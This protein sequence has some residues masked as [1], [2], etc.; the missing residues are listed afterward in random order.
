M[1]YLARLESGIQGLDTLLQGGLV[2]GASYIVQGRPGSGKT[3]FANQ[4]AFHHARNGGRVLF[5]TLLSES[6]ER[7]FQFLSTLSFFD[8]QRV[9]DEIQFVSAF[10]TLESEGLEEVVKL[11]RRE[12]TRQKATV[13]VVDGVLNARSRAEHTIDTKKFIAELQGHAAFAGCTTLFLTSARLDDSSPEHTMVDG[14]IEL[15]EELLANRAIRRLHLRK[16]R[17]SGAVPGLHE[18]QITSQGVV[19][20]PRLEAVLGGRGSADD[21]VEE[22]VPS[23]VPDLDAMTGGGLQR[24]SATLV[25]GASGTGK[26][27]LGL[28]FLSC[29]TPEEPG[30]IFGFYE[31]EGRMV[32]KADALGLGLREQI[33]SGA[34]RLIW[35][36]TTEQFMDMLAYRLLDAVREG[37]YR[38]VFIDSLGA[39]ARAS[40]EPARQLEF[41]TALINELRAMGVTVMATWEI[42]NVFDSSAYMPAMELSSLFDNILMMR[43]AEVGDTLRRI[44]MIL[45]I[46]DSA[47]DASFRELLITQD[48]IRLAKAFEDVPQ[49][50]SIGGTATRS[51]N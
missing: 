27:S 35:Q 22:A 46:R 33:R 49:T 39:I 43:F 34:V 37:G 30:L 25:T 23:G 14:V 3:I 40:A 5:A 6:H 20:Y 16:T 17:G 42:R 11:L 9:G 1:E 45:K 28:S 26:T 51:G 47:F 29:C 12:I 15:G 31:T 50:V 13:L 32:R 36:P 8:R 10:D 44:L 24:R 4:I 7:L 48:G 18:F 21:P 2:A 19:V 38:R 41:F